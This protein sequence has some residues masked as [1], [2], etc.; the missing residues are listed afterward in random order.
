MQMCFYLIRPLLFP[1]LFTIYK[2]ENCFILHNTQ[3]YKEKYGLFLFG[4]RIL[5]HSQFYIV[6]MECEGQFILKR[7]NPIVR[8]LLVLFQQ[9]MRLDRRTG[10]LISWWGWWQ[11]TCS[12]KC[13]F[14]KFLEDVSA[15]FRVTSCSGH[16]P[17]SRGK[18]KDLDCAKPDQESRCLLVLFKS[19]HFKTRDSKFG[20][21]WL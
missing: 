8:W 5:P 6:R 1:E 12:Q 19:Y 3:P 9:R 7:F 14:S 15:G 16:D 10:Q 17:V 20:W 21:T 11:W 18:D 2:A 4:K 13:P